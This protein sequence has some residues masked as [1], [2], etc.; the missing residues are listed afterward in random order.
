MQNG[1]KKIM[2]FGIILNH[3]RVVISNSI[4]LTSWFL[5]P[6]IN[7]P[8]MVKNLDALYKPHCLFVI[9]IAH[10][11]SPGIESFSTIVYKFS[12]EQLKYILPYESYLYSF[13]HNLITNEQ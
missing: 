10:N 2:Y 8:V 5:L 13:K 7:Q 1:I 4:K 3:F 12:L 9:P 6:D 11:K